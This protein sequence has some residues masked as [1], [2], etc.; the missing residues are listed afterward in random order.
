MTLSYIINS[1]LFLLSAA[2]IVHSTDGAFPNPAAK[3]YTC[4]T[5]NKPPGRE[6]DLLSETKGDTQ[7]L[8]IPPITVEGQLCTLTRLNRDYD[9]RVY[10]PVAKSYLPPLQPRP[11]DATKLEW[12]VS[13]GRYQESTSIECGSATANGPTSSITTLPEWTSGEYLCQITLEALSVSDTGWFLSTFTLQ[14]YYSALTQGGSTG[15]KVLA[16][17]FLSLSTWGPSKFVNVLFDM[18]L[19][20]ML[21]S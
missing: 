12:M 3:K 10:V 11:I 19:T 9:P 8:V 1:T 16:S 21:F 20:C 17:R 6:L 14:D 13:A 18:Y 2:S 7:Y 4:S 15:D 5:A